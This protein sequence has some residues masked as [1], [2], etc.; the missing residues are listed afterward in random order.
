MEKTFR[1]KNPCS[2]N[3]VDHL[4]QRC[5]TSR[6]NRL[7]LKGSPVSEAPIDEDEDPKRQVEEPDRVTEESREIERD[8]LR[9]RLTTKQSLKL[10]LVPDFSLE[11]IKEMESRLKKARANVSELLHDAANVSELLHGALLVKSARFKEKQWHDLNGSEKLSF[12]EA[13]SKQCNAWEENAAAKVIPPAEAKVFW[14]TLRKQGLQDRVMQ[15][16]F[17]F[18]DKNE[19][20]NTTENP[21]ETKASARIVI[22]DTQIQ[23][24]WKPSISCWLSVP[25]K[26]EKNWHS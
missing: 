6:Q 22:L 4:R 24:C 2:T 14:R 18:V 10:G 21:V 7:L 19:G 13:V 1:G 23:M 3:L 17:V 9:R 26:D 16:L 15:S 8:Q 12:L 5:L 11:E 25:V 20:K